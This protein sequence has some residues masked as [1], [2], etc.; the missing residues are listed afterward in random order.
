MGTLISDLNFFLTY[1]VETPLFSIETNNKPKKRIWEENKEEKIQK[2]T[3]REMMH[4]A[5]MEL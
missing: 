3:I 5:R 4:I 1:K 2:L